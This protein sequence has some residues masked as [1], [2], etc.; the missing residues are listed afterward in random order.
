MPGVTYLH[1][2][3]TN[4][5]KAQAAGFTQIRDVLSYSI[6]GE[7][8]LLMGKGEPI[9]GARSHAAVCP[10]LVDKKLDE[11]TGL[12]PKPMELDKPMEAEEPK[13]DV[14]PRMGTAPKK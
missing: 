8:V 10:V 3:A 12:G 6:R 1:C 11:L 4:I 5:A 7:S 14:K 9:R 2:H 13:L